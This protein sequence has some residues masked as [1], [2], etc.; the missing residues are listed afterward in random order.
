MNNE[1]EKQK[2][3]LEELKLRERRVRRGRVLVAIVFFLVW[4][5]ASRGGLIN[6]FIFSSPTRCLSATIAMTRNGSLPYHVA[7]T[8]Y[9]TIISFLIVMVVSPGVALIMWRFRTLADVL[10]PYLIALN[11]LPKSALAPVLIVWLGNRMRTVIAAAV[12]ISV[13]A[14]T[15]T[16]LAGFRDTDEDKIRLIKTLGGGDLDVMRLVVLPSSLP[17]F[18]STMKVNIGLCL[19]GVIIGEFLAANAGLGYLIIYGSQVFKMDIVILSIVL[20]CLLSAPLSRLLSLPEILI[21]RQNRPKTGRK[22][23]Q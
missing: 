9:E 18:F 2:I 23:N 13:F 10:E 5:L 4:E 16:L 17:I 11:S 6:D 7:V 20:L 21:K 14:S 15:L 1:T 19:V 8:L 22:E 12:M 3:Y